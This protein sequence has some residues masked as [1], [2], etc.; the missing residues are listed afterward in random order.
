M[1]DADPL[2]ETSATPDL[3]GTSRIGILRLFCTESPQPVRPVRLRLRA[4]SAENL[5][6]TVL[7]SAASSPCVTSTIESP[8]ASRQ[9]SLN[10]NPTAE[11]LE[12]G[13]WANHY[14]MRNARDTE[15]NGHLLRDLVGFS[16][17][18]PPQTTAR[19]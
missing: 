18:F 10:V 7:H 5:Q 14:D 4:E 19:Q 12:I 6:A 15:A 9:P 16:G 1:A 11:I 3:C 2:V 13:R 8:P 17:Q